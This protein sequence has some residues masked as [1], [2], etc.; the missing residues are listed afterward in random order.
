[1]KGLIYAENLREYLPASAVPTSLLL[2]SPIYV[3]FPP[4]FTRTFTSLAFRYPPIFPCKSILD[5]LLKHYLI[6]L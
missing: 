2:L 6:P 1:M 3:V 5:L 4:E